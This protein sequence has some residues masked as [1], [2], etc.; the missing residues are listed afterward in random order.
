VLVFCQLL[1]AGQ[2]LVG[3]GAVQSQAKERP[4]VVLEYEDKQAMLSETYA[5]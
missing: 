1:E 5:E 3:E 2:I 4:V